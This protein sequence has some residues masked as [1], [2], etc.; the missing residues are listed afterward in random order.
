MPVPVFERKLN[1]HFGMPVEDRLPHR[2]FIKVDVEKGVDDLDHR[3]LK[4]F[5]RDEN[6]YLR[7][8]DYISTE[9]IQSTSLPSNAE[10]LQRE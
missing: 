3:G 5:R 2:V 8:A 4:A 10:A 7:D 1:R 6:S 9:L